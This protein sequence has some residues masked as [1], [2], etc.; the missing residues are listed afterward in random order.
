M[1]RRRR[2]RRMR[3]RRRRIHLVKRKLSDFGAHR[4]LR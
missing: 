2:G 4:C 1:R 3:G